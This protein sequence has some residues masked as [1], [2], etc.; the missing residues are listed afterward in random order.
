MKDSIICG[1]ALEFYGFQHQKDKAIEECSELIQAL[2]RYSNG[3]ATDEDIITEIADVQ[4]MCE[5]LAQ[6]FGKQK[7]SKEHFRKLRR[8]EVRIRKGDELFE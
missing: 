6:K 2:S 4:I 3:R 1:K 5:Q 7:V 8:L